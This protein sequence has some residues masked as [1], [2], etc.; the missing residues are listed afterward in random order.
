MWPCSELS[1]LSKFVHEK[2]TR[3]ECSDHLRKVSAD[4]AMMGSVPFLAKFANSSSRARVSRSNEQ[5]ID[6]SARRGWPG[7]RWQ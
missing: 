2:L 4:F 1:Q 6:R 5:L 3:T 7:Q